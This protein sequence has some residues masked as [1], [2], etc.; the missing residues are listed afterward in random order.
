[1]A[2]HR[3]GG[4]IVVFTD[5]GWWRNLTKGAPA[6]LRLEGR[7]VPVRSEA[8]RDKEELRRVFQGLQSAEDESKARRMRM[9]FGLDQSRPPADA[10]IRAA[11]AA[12]R[13]TG[14]DWRML[15]FTPAEA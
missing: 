6:T 4:E 15:R 7:D 14:H 2:Y 8:V 13:R 3:V 12:P 5:S 10:D 11:L 9:I 1:V